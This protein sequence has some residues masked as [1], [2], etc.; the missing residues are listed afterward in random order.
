MEIAEK[1]Q[2]TPSGAGMPVDLTSRIE[3]WKK[4]YGDVYQITVDDPEECPELAGVQIIC[5]QPGR[6]Q[7]SRLVKDIAG[8]AL[9]AQNNFFFDCL[10]YPDA[11]LVKQIVDKKPGLMIA[12]GNE[13]QK[14]TGTNQNFT[15]T[16]L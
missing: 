5:R 15:T 2:N 3:N 13:L 4:Q 8:D 10:L 12:L 11:E 9:K 7:L 16:K 6:A 1:N 14:L